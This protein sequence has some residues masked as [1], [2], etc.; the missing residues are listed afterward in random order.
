MPDYY[1]C[2]ENDQNS[3]YRI[4]LL[5]T[6]LLNLVTNAPSWKRG[7]SK[8]KQSG[9]MNRSGMSAGIITNPMWTWPKAFATKRCLCN[10][11]NAPINVKHIKRYKAWENR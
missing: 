11:R 3:Q 8:R 5:D 7:A 10:D 9:F 2:D 1:R 6:D 4:S